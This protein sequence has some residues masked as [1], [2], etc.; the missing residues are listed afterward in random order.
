MPS[1]AYL[2]R[3]YGISE[4]EWQEMWE[5]QEKE[6]AICGSRPKAPVV[7][8]DHRTGY[9]RGLICKPCNRALAHIKDSAEL[10]SAIADYL[11]RPP[12]YS[13]VGKR[14]APAK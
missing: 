11:N 12:A 9:V 14:K 8:H 1:D 13:I 10:A 5:W 3:T 4:E 2:K 6:C 7:D